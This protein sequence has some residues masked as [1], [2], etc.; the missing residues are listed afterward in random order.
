[1]L[2]F[3]KF[4]F[5]NDIFLITIQVFILINLFGVSKTFFHEN[6]LP[7]LF[8]PTYMVRNN[9]GLDFYDAHFSSRAG[10]NEVH[11]L[12]QLITICSNLRLSFLQTDLFQSSYLRENTNSEDM[13]SVRNI[14]QVF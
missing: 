6:V 8:S 3:C 2:Q 9:F 4:V 12:R 11:F 1:M 5:F 10:F 13:S 14:C 7:T